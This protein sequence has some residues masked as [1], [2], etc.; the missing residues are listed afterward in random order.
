MRHYRTRLLSWVITSPIGGVFTL[1][2]LSHV[3]GPVS[4]VWDASVN[5][6]RPAAFPPSPPPPEFIWLCSEISQVRRHRPTTGHPVTQ[7][8]R[9]PATWPP[10][11]YQDWTS[12]SEQTMT[13]RTHH[14]I[15]GHFCHWTE[16]PK[17]LSI[18]RVV[19]LSMFSRL[20]LNPRRSP[21]GLKPSKLPT[22]LLNSLAYSNTS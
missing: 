8:H 20:P 14:A 6:P 11:R 4:G 18:Q 21:N 5:C 16:K 2:S 9:L 15:V 19:S 12:T 10:D 7:M 1:T 13:F 22:S 17:P 3:P